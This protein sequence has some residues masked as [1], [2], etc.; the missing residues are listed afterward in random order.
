MLRYATTQVA[1]LL[2]RAIVPKQPPTLPSRNNLPT[3]ITTRMCKKKCG[4]D[5]DKEKEN[6][7]GK[8]KGKG[9]DSKKV[10]AVEVHGPHG[11]PTGEK[12]IIAYFV[13]YFDRC[14]I[15][16][17][18]LRQGMNNL[19]GMDLIIDPPIIVAALHACRRNNDIALAIR[20]LEGCKEK[21]A[22]DMKV[23]YPYIMNEIKPTLLELGVPTLEELHYDEPELA[24]ESVYDM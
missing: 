21:C 2:S 9:K 5:K 15:D 7:K 23:A 12:E 11:V 3:L 14:D 6:E 19:L 17:W 4:K 10:E 1:N 24:L 22:G 16:G 13:T 18:E 20:W 8:D